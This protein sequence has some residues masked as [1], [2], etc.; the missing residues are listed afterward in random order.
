MQYV[1]SRQNQMSMCWSISSKK[2]KINVSEKLNIAIVRL[3]YTHKVKETVW[4]QKEINKVEIPA[5]EKAPT[6][7]IEVEDGLEDQDT[8]IAMLIMN[9][10]LN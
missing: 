9:S 3:D 8:I 1:K 5:P 6:D 10:R 4:L 7:D 2:N